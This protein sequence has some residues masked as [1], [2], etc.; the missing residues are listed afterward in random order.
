M[1]KLKIIIPVLI[2]IIGFI[3]INITGKTN[4]K[5]QAI[6]NTYL[7][8]FKN[9]VILIE[10]TTI[11]D[12]ITGTLREFIIENQKETNRNISIY[13]YINNNEISIQ[14]YSIDNINGNLGNNCIDIN[15]SFPGGEIKQ[16]SFKKSNINEYNKIVEELKAKNFEDIKQSKLNEK[17]SNLQNTLN[18][19]INDFEENINILNNSKFDYTDINKEL[20]NVENAYND[21]INGASDEKDFLYTVIEY[22]IT[23]VEYQY[24]QINF[25]IDD[26]KEDIED[27]EE[28]RNT[29]ESNLSLYKDL[30][31]SKFQYENLD[32]IL[33]NSYTIIDTIKNKYTI[34]LDNSNKIL[35][36]AYTYK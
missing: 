2:I 32:K 6:N 26:L 34:Y 5:Y 25:Y 16:V 15:W 29:I 17:I 36:K 28:L 30:N 8:E 23:C 9:A 27:I 11:E 24:D 4:Q 35:K 22:Q 18:N 33:S 13:G 20:K 3:I 1:N 12:K 19:Q 21:Y 31:K 14:S 10:F 7:H